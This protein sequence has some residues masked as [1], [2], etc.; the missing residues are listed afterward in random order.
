MEL[1]TIPD[2]MIPVINSTRF[3]LPQESSEADWSGAAL[4]EV[5]FQVHGN[6]PLRA[7]A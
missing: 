1:T 3:V 4:R 7:A 5:D 6:L 2:W